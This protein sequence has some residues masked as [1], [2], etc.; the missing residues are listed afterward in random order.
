MPTDE[1]KRAL[2]QQKTADAEVDFTE[3]LERA[4][5]VPKPMLYRILYAAFC[6]SEL[7]VD[8]RVEHKDQ[9]DTLLPNWELRNA[10]KKAMTDGARRVVLRNAI[11][12]CK[13]VNVKAKHLVPK[14]D[15]AA[16]CNGCPERMLCM[17][18]S[19]STPADCYRWRKA[20]LTVYPLRLTDTHVEVE[21]QQPAGRHYV[22]L[23]NITFKE[24]P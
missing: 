10:I 21:A 6:L 9:W 20:S 13:S 5:E 17:A 2:E 23:K 4:L 18:E 12:E 8:W 11:L 16:I 15:L 19:L 7:E 14:D 22:P 24:K 1:L 3:V